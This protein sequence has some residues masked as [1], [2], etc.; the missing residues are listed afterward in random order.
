MHV[1]SALIRAEREKRAWSQEHLAM[2]ARL[3]LRTVQRIEA[4]GV[5]SYDSV[6]AI[7]A[8]YEM[9]PADLR[10]AT[11]QEG[12][13]PELTSVPSPAD[14]A[15]A[16][17]LASAKSSEE[18]KRRPGWVRTLFIGSRL[19]R[20]DRR[21][22]QQLERL[23]VSA[24]LVFAVLGAFAVFDVFLPAEA[25]A[26][27][28]FGST[29]LF[30]AAYLASLHVRVGDRLMIWP[31]LEPRHPASW[32][33]FVFRAALVA[34]LLSVSLLLF[35]LWAQGQ[36]QDG[37]RSPHS[38]SFVD[39]GGGVRLEVLDWGGS[40][41]ALVLLA[42]LGNTAHG[43][44]DFAPELARDYR[45]YGVTRRGHGR[46][47]LS[48]AGYGFD[49]LAADVM[50]V[51]RSLAIERPVLIGH[52]I[53]GEELHVLGARYADAIRGVVYIDA[54]FNRADGS[55]DYD[56]VFAALPRM[57]RPGAEDLGSLAALG[58]YLSRNGV[59]VLPDAELRNRYVVNSDGRV[60]G[61]RSPDPSVQ[62]GYTA[63]LEEI[64]SSYH[65]EPI[66][67]PALAFYA[68]PA[69]AADLA[70]PWYDMNDAA[71]RARVDTLYL[72]ARERFDRHTRWFGMFAKGGKVVSLA[73]DH[74]LFVSN[75]AEVLE[76]IRRFVAALD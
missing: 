64:R 73:G 53:A 43:F 75:R 27:L 41:Q 20:M 2:V 22:L 8:A 58:G 7:A 25:A 35:P 34:S 56:A 13:S 3:G 11:M 74:S 51:I 52:S 72:R 47:S 28:L 50:R 33:R 40:G 55:E 70:R 71:V 18:W 62:Q 4:T 1:N 15:S 9:A 66:W 5:A 14:N 42:G 29:L 60:A 17:E 61:P 54:A 76:G 46:S 49:L 31:W 12:S 39:V 16:A 36:G 59:A 24:A 19:V 32:L 69:S 44:D 38:S 65:P 6:R 45:V 37:D 68:V 10:L 57:P 67:V 26:P 21:Q 63:V 48:P 30:A 23:E